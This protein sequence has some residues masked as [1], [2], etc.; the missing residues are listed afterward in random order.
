MESGSQYYYRAY[1]TNNAGTVL[2]EVKTFMTQQVGTIY[3][4]TGKADPSYES[5]TIYYSIQTNGNAI[6]EYGISYDEENNYFYDLDYSDGHFIKKKTISYSAGQDINN[7]NQTFF[8]T[9]LVHATQYRYCAYVKYTDEA[10]NENILYGEIKTFETKA[11]KVPTVTTKEAQNI[12]STSVKLY[13]KV[14]YYIINTTQRGFYISSDPDAPYYTDFDNY[15]DFSWLWRTEIVG[16]SSGTYKTI[17]G[18]TPNTT[19]YYIAW[20]TNKGGN[21]YG[22][23][24][25]FTTL[26]E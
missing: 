10:G 21:G 9:N 11:Y 4:S 12:T 1:A 15:F 23:V 5:V 25:S 2:G 24:M 22:E 17:T 26:A 8:I 6:N 7:L 18:L 16:T 3:I 19:Y 14:D 13:M 20:A